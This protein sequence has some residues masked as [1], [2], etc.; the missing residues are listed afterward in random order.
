MRKEDALRTLAHL[1]PEI[2]ARFG[3]TALALFGSVARDEA[4]AESDVDVLVTFDGPADFDRF[5]DLKFLLEEH[6]GVPVDLVT[7][8]GLR[9]RLRP[10]FERDAIHVA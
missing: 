8:H 1:K 4:G 2:V 5:M 3:V 10:A 9:P 6:L 7:S